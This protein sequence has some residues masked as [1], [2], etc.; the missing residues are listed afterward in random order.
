MARR[1]AACEVRMYGAPI[2]AAE[3]AAVVARKRRRVNGRR[4]MG[5]LLRSGLRWRAILTPFWAAQNRLVAHYIGERHA[6]GENAD[7][8]LKDEEHLPPG[9]HL[10]VG[11]TAVFGVFHSGYSSRRKPEITCTELASACRNFGRVHLLAGYAP[12]A[13]RLHSSRW[14]HDRGKRLPH[15]RLVHARRARC[16]HGTAAAD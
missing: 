11:G 5:L 7:G 4:L 2:T 1:P 6:E 12:A 10:V 15:E 8:E 16:A 14:L 9:L 3:A 13:L